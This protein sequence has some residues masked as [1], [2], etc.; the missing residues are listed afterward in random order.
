MVLE[1][2]VLS[3]ALEHF[4]QESLSDPILSESL[5]RM[6]PKLRTAAF[7]DLAAK[8]IEPHLV[9]WWCEWH[10]T[11]INAS[12]DGMRTYAQSLLS[13][14]LLWAEFEDAVMQGK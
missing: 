14:L 8:I 13:L 7:E 3:A 9:A 5:K 12:S 4:G 2:H 6:P 10:H 11:K 1:G